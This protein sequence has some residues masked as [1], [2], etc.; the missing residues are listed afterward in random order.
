MKA[1]SMAERLKTFLAQHGNTLLNDRDRLRAHLQRLF[2]DAPRERRLLVLAVV[3]GAVHDV[4]Q[5]YGGTSTQ[6][7]VIAEARR[8]YEE[9]GIDFALAKKALYAWAIALGLPVSRNVEDEIDPYADLH[10]DDYKV[11]A[12]EIVESLHKRAEAGD[13]VAQNEL[14]FI[15]NKGLYGIEDPVEAVR[16]FRRSAEQGHAFAQHNLGWMYEKGRGVEMNLTQ[17]EVWYRKSAA[18]GNATAITRLQRVLS[19]TVR[20]DAL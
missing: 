2:P 14:G 16:W 15:Y 3:S 1:F 6:V 20:E 17:A 13:M 12:K 5:P 10:K 7:R 4:L 18:Q 8:L 11:R 19:P 9:Y